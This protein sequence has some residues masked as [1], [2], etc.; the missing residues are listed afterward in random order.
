MVLQVYITNS[1]II[2]IM[3]RAFSRVF[4]IFWGCLIVPDAILSEKT[5]VLPEPQGPVGR[6]W[7]SFQILIA[8]SQTPQ[9]KLQFHGQHRANVSRG[10]P[11]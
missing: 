8:L 2:I 7:S 1:I 6:R 11:V 5:N 4:N 3:E 10:V 9:P